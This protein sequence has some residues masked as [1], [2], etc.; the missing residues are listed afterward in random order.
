MQYMSNNED[1]LFCQEY[2][3]ATWDCR[4]QFP[5]W[6]Q[7]NGPSCL[8]KKDSEQKIVLRLYQVVLQNNNYTRNLLHP[9]WKYVLEV[10]K[11]SGVI[12]T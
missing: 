9:P 6:R 2:I 12:P 10:E 7:K 11:S 3:L 8:T 5:I 1:H 4:T